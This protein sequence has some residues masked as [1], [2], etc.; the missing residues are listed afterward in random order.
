MDIFAPLGPPELWI[1]AYVIAL[2]AGIIKG[3]VGFAM[4]LILLSGLSSFVAP[5]LA[6]ACLI[7]PTLLTNAWQALRQGPRAA[8]HSLKRFKLFLVCGGAVLLLSAQLVP[9]LPASVLLLII[10]VPLLAYAG[11]SLAGRPLRL[12]PRPGRGV[13]AG[14]GAA[15]GFIGGLSGVWGPI[16]VAMLTAMETEKREQVRIQGVMYGLGALALAAAHVTSGVLNAQTLPLSLALVP[17][18]LLGIWT[19][20]QIQDRIDQALF[21]RLT[22][23]ILLLAGLNLLRRGIIAL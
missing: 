6:L 13:E 18:A 15:A 7:V 14:M 20:F 5:D 9:V 17:P 11:T 8:L 1:F 10:A 21:K 2:A 16:T 3:V 19:G 22:L 23:W 4:P 12:P